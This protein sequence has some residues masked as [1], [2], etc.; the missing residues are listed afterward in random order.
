MKSQSVPHGTAAHGNVCH[1]AVHCRGQGHVSVPDSDCSKIVPI[2][3]QIVALFNAL[4]VSMDGLSGETAHGK[5]L[6]PDGIP[7]ASWR[8]YS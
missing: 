2:D 7:F 8:A 1:E 5:Q 4:R 6:R 3:L